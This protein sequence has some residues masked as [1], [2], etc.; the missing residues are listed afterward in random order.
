MGNWA[1]IWVY[2]SDSDYT[3]APRT[4]TDVYMIYNGIAF[5][6]MDSSKGHRCIICMCALFAFYFFAVV[7]LIW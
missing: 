2:N 3:G 4:T 7:V 1:D 6:V 5:S